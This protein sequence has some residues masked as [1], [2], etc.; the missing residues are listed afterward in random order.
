MAKKDNQPTTENRRGYDNWY[1]AVH[2]EW[3]SLFDH[4]DDATVAA[5]TRGIIKYAKHGAIPEL[6]GFGA[7]MFA[8]MR[9]TIDRDLERGRKLAQ[10]TEKRKQSTNGG[11]GEKKGDYRGIK[12]GV[13]GYPL[14]IPE[15]NQNKLNE[16]KQKNNLPTPLNPP[17]SRTDASSGDGSV[18]GSV[19][20]SFSPENKK[21][22]TRKP[23]SYSELEDYVTEIG[24]STFDTEALWYEMEESD[25]QIPDK[26]SGNLRPLKSWK[27][28]V[29][30]RAENSTEPD[31]NIA[32][33]DPNKPILK[34]PEDKKLYE[35]YVKEGILCSFEGYREYILSKERRKSRS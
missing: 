16:N 35:R 18:G 34:T 22:I 4:A 28:F 13:E 2:L 12:R 33:R 8:M 19:N 7:T 1:V 30:Y 26:K 31:K 17:S 5:L 23:S 21:T 25:W 15:Q 3:E 9:E 11:R 24:Y 29:K 10:D 20:P 14:F 6:D 27:N 32:T